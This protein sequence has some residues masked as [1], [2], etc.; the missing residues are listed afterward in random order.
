MKPSK[1]TKRIQ[2]LSL[3]WNLST[4]DPPLT[5]TNINFPNFNPGN[6]NIKT[7]SSRWLEAI[8]AALQVTTIKFYLDDPRHGCTKVTS[9]NKVLTLQGSIDIE[10]SW[11]FAS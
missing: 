9:Q 1:N 4:I 3:F 7:W 2:L 6:L 11:S 8:F 10:S 5:Q